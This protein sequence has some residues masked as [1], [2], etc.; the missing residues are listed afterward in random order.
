MKLKL[1]LL[2]LLILAAA[3]PLSAQQC[4]AATTSS[5]QRTVNPDKIYDAVDEDP[6]FPGG[7]TAL[8][9][10]IANHIQYPR[11]AAE[12]YIQGKV[13]VKFAVMSD[14]SI[15]EVKVVRGKDPELDKEAIRVV[16][17]LPRFTPGKLNGQP[18]N[19]WY[20]TSITFRLAY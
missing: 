8:M 17:L 15:G 19:V 16:K 2:A 20:V 14:G 11:G 5:S 4:M 7:D 3:G 9:Q 1:P 10:Y 12:N 13:I 6:V 18:V